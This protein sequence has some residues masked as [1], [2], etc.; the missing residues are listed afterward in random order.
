MKTITRVLY[1]FLMTGAGIMHFLKRENFKRIMPPVIP[2]RSFFVL[3]T[4]VCEILA[5]IALLFNIFRK[6]ASVL[7]E[8]FLVLIFPVNMYMA[9]KKMPLRPGDKAHP[10]ALWLRLP[11]QLP[12]ISGA[13]SWRKEKNQSPQ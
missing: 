4:G 5:G 6:S 3:F 1:S 9:I 11:L 8:V 13:R 7:L 10:V 12:L 2:F